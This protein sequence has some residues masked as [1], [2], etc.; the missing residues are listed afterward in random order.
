VGSETESIG[1]NQ[2]LDHFYDDIHFYR[3]FLSRFC[4]G[5]SVDETLRYDCREWSSEVQG[6]K[7]GDKIDGKI[8][9]ALWMLNYLGAP[10]LCFWW[11]KAFKN[12]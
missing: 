5:S 10:N 11:Q 2:R 7:C 4:H 1:N 8:I 3:E 9:K 12:C 6:Q